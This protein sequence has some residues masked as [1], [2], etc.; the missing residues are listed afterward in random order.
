MPNPNGQAPLYM[1]R[2]FSNSSGAT[3]RRSSNISSV[4]SYTADQG[5]FGFLPK[6][7]F[8]FQQAMPNNRYAVGSAAG[9]SGQYGATT[10]VDSLST[11]DS[12][13]C[14]LL[15]DDPQRGFITPNDF[16]FVVY[17]N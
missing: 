12:A 4:Q 2:A 11:F 10:A 13:E 14:T 7:R 8:N 16:A 5:P 3:I 17:C 15:V 1:A 9:R 6:W